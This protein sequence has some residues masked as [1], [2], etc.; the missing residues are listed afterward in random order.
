MPERNLPFFEMFAK[1]HPAP[2]LA[3]Q[4][5][6]LA[7]T[8]LTPVFDDVVNDVKNVLDQSEDLLQGFHGTAADT[9]ARRGAAGGGGAAAGRAGGHAPAR[10]RGARG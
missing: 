9:R 6:K 3:A 8:L 1:Y 10:R 4:L 5:E 7:D 2:A